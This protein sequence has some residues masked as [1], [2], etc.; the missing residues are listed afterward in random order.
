[1]SC[2]KKKIC[3]FALL[4]FSILVIAFI[5]LFFFSARYDEKKSLR[6]NAF[7]GGRFEIDNFLDLDGKPVALD[8]KTSELTIIDFWFN[9]CPSC[10]NE[11]KQF[12]SVLNGNEKKVSIVSVSINNYQLW[13]NTLS[14]D[15]PKLSFLRDRISN[16]KQIVLKSNEDPGLRNDI[17][18]DNLALVAEEFNSNSFPT[19]LVVNKQGIIVATPFSAVRFIKSNILH[20]N[21][22]VTF[23][24]DR[25]TWN[26][27]VFVLG[28]LII[29]LYCAVFWMVSS[30]VSKVNR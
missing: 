29:M 5:V 3:V 25:S 2:S 19:Y 6:L 21:K 16:W 20:Q 4:L 28:F 7:I 8:F 13:K 27:E 12:S 18:T 22:F 14:S 10:L 11:M 17:P 1:M 24:T 30:M 23:L 26:H 9:T 15:D